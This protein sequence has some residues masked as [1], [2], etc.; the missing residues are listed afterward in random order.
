[1]TQLA[2][3]A[4]PLRHRVDRPRGLVWE[5]HVIRRDRRPRPLRRAT[6]LVAAGALALAVAPVG[7]AAQETAPPA[8]STDLACPGAPSSDFV[9][10]AGSVH[11]G[12]VRCLADLGLTEGLRGGERYGPR[13]DVERG[14]M[15]TFI[16]RFIELATGEELPDGPDAF[17]DDDGSTHEAAID[18]LAAIGVVEGRRG[19][20]FDPRASVTRGQMASFVVRALD[21]IDDGA[22]NGSYPPAGRDAFGDDDGSTHEP[23][24]DALAR[25]GVVQGFTD[26]TYRPGQAVKRDQMAS[27]LVRAYDVVLDEL[28]PG[29][30]V[31]E[32]DFA[33][34]I[35]RSAYGVPHIEAEDVGSLAFGMGYASAADTLCELMDRVMT[36]N[37]ERSRYLGPGSG[38]SNVVSDLYHA[39]LIAD[40]TYDGLDLA[41]GATP[42]SPS[43]EARDAVR[44]YVAGVNRYLA[45]TPTDQLDSRC[46]DAPWVR[47]L[48][49]EEYWR[50]AVTYLS[51]QLQQA[52]QVN[53]APPA[54]AA[55]RFAPADADLE[56]TAEPDTVGSNAYAFGADVTGGGGV[57]LG[58]PHYPWAG[59]LRFYRAHLTI[60]GE[61]NVV[62]AALI[63]TPFI[64]IG[65]TDRIAWTHTVSTAQRYGF[66]ELQLAPGDPTSY[67]FDGEVVPMEQ[68]PVS[69]EIA[70]DEGGTITHAHTFYATPFG[71]LIESPDGLPWNEQNAYVF[72]NTVENTRLVDQYLAMYEADDVGELFD[73][74]G[75]HQ[76]TAYNTTATD[77]D[78]GTLFTDA[79]AIPH[80]TDATW[81][82]CATSPTA[83]AFRAQRQPMLD[84]WRSEC[85]WGTDD[86]A[87]TPGIFG[88]DSVPSLFRDDY[89][90]QSNDS[91]WLTNPLEPLEG[92]PRI[93]GVERTE[94]SL[95]TRLGLV[96]VEERLDG[97]DG[98]GEAGVVDLETVQEMLY[99]NRVH[100]AELVRDDLVA[101]CEA[102]GTVT[103]G[104]DEVALAEAC[105]VLDAWDL[106]VDRDS[107]GA[108][109]FVRWIARIGA[110]PWV[111]GFDA[112]DPVHTPNTL[113]TS[114]DR[115]LEALGRAVRDVEAAG[116]DLDAPWGEVQ[117]EVRRGQPI[118]IHGGPGNAGTFNVISPSGSLPWTSI[119]SGASWIMAVEFTDDG[120]ISEG[121]LTYSQS[122]DP[123]SPWYADQTQLYSQKGW[124]PLLFDPADVRQH[125]HTTEHVTGDG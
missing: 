60:P 54:A 123:E 120:P 39:R 32:A 38:N 71:N 61:L 59:S 33:A 45:D 69:I 57:L 48:T 30:P 96:Q 24:I 49:A 6:S 99:A 34:T 18:A 100:G 47:P 108:H 1:M 111:N 91:H 23:S 62:G 114:D 81:A 5:L 22:L 83:Q 68:I 36:A 15:A 2:P 65:H 26:G 56:E 77:A 37:G 85:Q 89:V 87:V 55:A 74:L 86:G 121:V 9:D 72:A 11:A 44:G 8:R 113:D 43:A 58:N 119:A 112:T 97:S 105:E 20:G 35:R 31:E 95:R 90:T 116:V 67:V 104:D 14:Q 124:D 115:V 107:R 41:P 50:V 52:A 70:D 63:N 27:F 78:G 110:I 4:R 109:L 98:L 76:A 25:L 88:P 103:I 29:D 17:D 13:L 3:R 92:Y 73:A 10:I 118:P 79:G 106:R 80:I 82:G 66:F 28:D 93:F 16:A 46:S 122:P 12:A 102:A 101:A 51:G 84:G 40:G 125:A 42:G 64:G 75:D 19:G 53:A 21:H 7:A 94:R 117:T